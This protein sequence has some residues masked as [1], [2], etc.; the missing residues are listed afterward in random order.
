M[1]VPFCLFTTEG[2]YELL[3]ARVYVFAHR[4]VL[5]ELPGHFMPTIGILLHFVVWKK[6]LSR[7]A[8]S[9]QPR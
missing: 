1:N 2:E 8:D 5:E 7:Q 9:Q 6:K 3:Q 4:G